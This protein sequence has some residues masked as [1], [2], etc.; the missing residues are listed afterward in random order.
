M[1]YF[2]SKD[3]QPQNLCFC[4]REN[5]PDVLTARRKGTS[6]GPST[7]IHQWVR[8]DAI[9]QCNVFNA[10][11]TRALSAVC[12]KAAELRGSR[13][14]SPLQAR[15]RQ[16]GRGRGEWQGGEAAQWSLF[17]FPGSFT[18]SNPSR[19]NSLHHQTSEPPCFFPRTL[20]F[21]FFSHSLGRPTKFFLI[22]LLKCSSA[23]SRDPPQSL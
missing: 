1:P 15:T 2:Q 12:T 13:R 6:P 19:S 11:H 20:N 9:I 4:V 10:T 23:L 17:E 8:G 21:H 16:P 3:I 5:A 18:Q 14:C 7:H 22:P